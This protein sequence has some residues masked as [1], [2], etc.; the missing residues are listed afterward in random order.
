MQVVDFLIHVDSLSLSFFFHKVSSG[1][2]NKHKQG[3]ICLTEHDEELHEVVVDSTASR[4]NDEDILVADTVANLDVGLLVGELCELDLAGRDAEAG[5]DLVD[6]GRVRAAY[7]D[8]TRHK[9][10][11]RESVGGGAWRVRSRSEFRRSIAC[12]R[13]FGCWGGSVSGEM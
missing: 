8:E 7:C 4:L 2:S 6:E 11:V 12:A 5:T 3:P 13:K 9:T 10:G 1:T